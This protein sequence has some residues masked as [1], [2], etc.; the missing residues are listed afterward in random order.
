MNQS[1][2]RKHS[3]QHYGTTISYHNTLLSWIRRLIGLDPGEFCSDQR[4]IAC[5]EDMR[6]TVRK[7]TGLGLGHSGVS[8]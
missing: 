8:G 6:S 7:I 2:L 3:T 5:H 4:K 1:T